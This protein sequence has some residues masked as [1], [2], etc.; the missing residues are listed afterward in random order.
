MGKNQKIEMS[1]YI[2]ISGFNIHDNNRGTAALSYGSL[3]FYKKKLLK[4]GQ[5]LINYRYYK[6]P[7]KSHNRKN[8]EEYFQL[9]GDKYLHT[10]LMYYLLKNGYLIN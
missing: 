2:L 6:N 5:Q 7:F 8:S 9:G 10:V 1:K 4:K 3:F